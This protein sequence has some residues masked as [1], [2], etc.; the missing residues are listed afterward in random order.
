[1]ESEKSNRTTTDKV[2][3]AEIA[4]RLL[5]DEFC[6]RTMSR[7]NAIMQ[8]EVFALIKSAELAFRECLESMINARRNDGKPALDPSVADKIAAHYE[9]A[10]AKHPYFCDRLFQPEQNEVRSIRVRA[11][12]LKGMRALC[13]V[14][15]MF[16]A[17]SAETVLDCELAEVYEAYARGDKAHAVEECYDAIAVL[18]RVVEECYDAIAVLLRMVDVLEGRQSL[19]DPNAPTDEA[20]KEGATK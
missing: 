10:R 3:E 19:G 8:Q 9:H 12:T 2:G 13:T 14:Q 17:L 15:K 18:L 5:K 7:I 11:I 6:N 16:Q 4:V 1:M 20:K